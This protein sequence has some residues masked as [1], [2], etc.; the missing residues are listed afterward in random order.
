MHEKVKTFL[1]TQEEI[2]QKLNEEAKKKTLL[3]LR[4]TEKI[5]S[6]NGWGT[7][8]YPYF[9]W[10][11]VNQV[12]RYYKLEPLEVTDEEYAEILKYADSP[13]KSNEP[14]EKNSIATALTVIAWS[15]FIIGFIIG[16]VVGDGFDHQIETTSAITFWIISFI[17][18]LTFLGFAEII[19]L[20]TAIKNK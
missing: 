10:D 19:K 18:G 9:E 15:I 3:S 13:I 6:P 20:L 8:E 17:S 11:T 12:G 2:Q 14:S 5:Y 7:D 4:L 1:E 16:I